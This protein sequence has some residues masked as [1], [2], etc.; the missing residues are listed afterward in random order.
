[1]SPLSADI[2]KYRATSVLSAEVPLPLKS[3]KPLIYSKY[4]LFSHLL[5]F[6][7]ISTSW[8]AIMIGYFH[9]PHKK[10]HQ[11]DMQKV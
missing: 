10:R 9:E 1:M 7:V 2:L 8:V 6:A 3:I 5:R 11:I 4:A